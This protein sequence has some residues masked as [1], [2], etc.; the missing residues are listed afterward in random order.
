MQTYI[1]LYEEWEPEEDWKE[2][3]MEDQ[4]ASGMNPD[5]I[6]WLEHMHRADPKNWMEVKNIPNYGP[7][8]R[9]EIEVTVSREVLH[10]PRII[11]SSQRVGNTGTEDYLLDSVRITMTRISSAHF[12]FRINANYTGKYQPSA[13]HTPNTSRI[14]WP[15]LQSPIDEFTIARIVKWIAEFNNGMDQGLY[16]PEGWS[17]IN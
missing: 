15:S 5:P 4:I 14:W 13:S 17:S 2:H 11:P 8:K 7:D 1:K 9:F 10:V 12:T 16:Q 3:A 6:E